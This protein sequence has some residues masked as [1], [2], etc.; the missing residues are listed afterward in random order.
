MEKRILGKEK[1]LFIFKVQ[2]SKQDEKSAGCQVGLRG[3][4]SKGPGSL[5]A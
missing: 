1:L 5:E 3:T 4:R 2:G